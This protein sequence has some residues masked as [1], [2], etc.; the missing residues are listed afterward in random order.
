MRSSLL[1]LL[2]LASCAPTSVQPDTD[3]FAKEI[4]GRAQGAT[5]SCISTFG[6]QN[7]RVV[8]PATVAY[9]QGKTI[10]IN[11]LRSACP[12]LSQFNTIIVEMQGSQY[13]SGDHVRGLE[14]GA[15][16]PGPTCF[17]GNWTAYTKP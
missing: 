7:L 3:V 13:C 11:H 6:G 5:S 17:L 12:A 8:N 14:P 10:Y 4:A 15:I 2:G 9:G 16:I 1:L